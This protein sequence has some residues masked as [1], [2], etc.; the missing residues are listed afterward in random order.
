M[1][2]EL[3]P[4]YIAA[5]GVLLDA[6]EALSPHEEALILVGAQAIYLHTGDFD[7]SVAAFTT[8]ADIT[9]DPRRLEPTPEIESTFVSAG[10][11]RGGRVGAWLT[12]KEIS[13]GGDTH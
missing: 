8:D 4:L 2:G 13:G 3:D 7:F 5:R 9:I 6:L 11:L 10:F 1:S 12:T